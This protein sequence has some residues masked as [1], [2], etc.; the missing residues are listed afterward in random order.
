MDLEL[1]ARVRAGPQERAEA[2]NALTTAF[3]C[4]LSF[5]CSLCRASSLETLRH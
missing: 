5:T 4:R 2:V 1:K 3:L